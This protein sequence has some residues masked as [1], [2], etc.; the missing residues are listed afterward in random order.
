MKK[1]IF[2]LWGTFILGACENVDIEKP[3]LMDFEQIAE[4]E[5]FMEQNASLRMN[6]ENG[7]TKLPTLPF[8]FWAR[9]DFG[10]PQGIPSTNE[11]GIIYFYIQNTNDVT[12]DFNLLTFFDP[13]ATN[14]EP[15]M[16]G[17]RWL[18][19]GYI[20]PY[21]AKSKG[22]GAVPFWIITAEQVTEVFE[23][24]SITMNELEALNPPPSKG[25]ASRFM[26]NLWPA[27]GGAPKVTNL[28]IAEGI[29]EDGEGLIED[30]QRF[31]FHYHYRS[32]QETFPDPEGAEIDVT[33]RLF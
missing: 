25:F 4:N 23:D 3:E 29:I 18:K 6:E 9:V 7:L 16:E 12:P 11:Y 13:T 27:G 1:L 2:L 10:L 26:E 8:P 19:P 21:M 15:S 30:G 5:G 20:F 14:S 22:K 24:G 31:T 17:D 32:D 28:V 33:F